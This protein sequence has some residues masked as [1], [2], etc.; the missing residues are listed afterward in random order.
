MTDPYPTRSVILWPKVNRPPHRFF[1]NV[2]WLIYPCSQSGYAE[3]PKGLCLK[4][5]EIV[6]GFFTGWMP[7]QSTVLKH[8]IILKALP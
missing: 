2:N 6:G 4:T 8:K 1:V 3:S 7:L 5:F